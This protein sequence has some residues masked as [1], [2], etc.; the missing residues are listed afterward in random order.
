LQAHIQNSS[1]VSKLTHVWNGRF[2]GGY[3]TR[4]YGQPAQA[5]H[6]V[7]L[8]MSQIIYM[9]EVAPFHYRPELAEAIQPL[10]AQLMQTCIAWAQDQAK[11]TNDV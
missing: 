7:Q 9:D 8:E 11:A 2:K 10:I 6:A 4:A 1:M 3:I 5:V